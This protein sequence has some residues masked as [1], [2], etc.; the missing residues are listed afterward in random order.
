M[1]T[2]PALRIA[3]RVVTHPTM[4]VSSR[5]SAV[6]AGLFAAGLCLLAGC[7]Q[8]E[9][10]RCEVDSDCKGDLRCERTT[11]NDGV[12]RAGASTP[13]IDAST[14]DRAPSDVAATT[15][16]ASTADRAATDVSADVA[17][18]ADAAV[19]A[20]DAPSAADSAADARPDTAAAGSD[21]SGG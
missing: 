13:L 10:D 16:V 1:V 15:D 4:P 20:P 8:G 21:A 3:G 11:G 12:C 19:A 6:V 2:T 14:A 9:G 18:G 17:V 7:A 5:P